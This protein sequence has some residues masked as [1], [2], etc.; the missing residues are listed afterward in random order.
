MTG[1]IIYNILT[2]IT[3]LQGVKYYIGLTYTIVFCLGTIMI[4]LNIFIQIVD[5]SYV[6]IKLK[7]KSSFAYKRLKLLQHVEKGSIRKDEGKRKGCFK[8][9]Y[10]RSMPKMSV[11]D[12]SSN[13]NSS[14]IRAKSVIKSKGRAPLMSKK[15]LGLKNKEMDYYYSYGDDAYSNTFK[16]GVNSLGKSRKE[17]IEMSLSIPQFS[18]I[19]NEDERSLSSQESG[20]RSKHEDNDIDI[21]IEIENETKKCI[22]ETQNKFNE[23]EQHINNI[24]TYI[25]EH[26]TNE[27]PIITNRSLLFKQLHLL[28]KLSQQLK[29]NLMKSQ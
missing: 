14:P 6:L 1:D 20:D 28:E 25:T 18:I 8:R 27:Q 5:D 21:E 29:T 23:I 3:Q 4:V 12:S 7:N 24:K 10:P 11:V 2:N 17:I 22:T 13:S 26:I 19:E 16:S 9:K 15:V